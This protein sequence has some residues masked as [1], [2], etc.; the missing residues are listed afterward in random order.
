MLPEIFKDFMIKKLFD[1]AEWNCKHYAL[2]HRGLDIL[3]YS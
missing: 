3:I 2:E 1:L